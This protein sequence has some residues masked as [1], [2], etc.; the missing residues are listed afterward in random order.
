[1]YR[2]RLGD[3]A[4]AASAA[5]SVAAS[6]AVVAVAVAV[7]AAAAAPRQ[8]AAAGTFHKPPGTRQQRSLCLRT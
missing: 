5:A 8:V 3:A 6:V 2:R 7:A 1:M 4:A